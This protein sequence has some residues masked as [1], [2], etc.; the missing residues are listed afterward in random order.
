MDWKTDTLYWS[1]LHNEQV[2]VY[3]ITT[4]EVSYLSVGS[5]QLLQQAAVDSPMNRDDTIIHTVVVEPK[6]QYLPQG[7]IAHSSVRYG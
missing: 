5:Q 2:A 6:R 4:S 1:T 3:N 7:T